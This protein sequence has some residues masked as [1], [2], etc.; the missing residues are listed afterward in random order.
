MIT[1]APKDEND[2]GLVFVRSKGSGRYIRWNQKKKL[3]EN[4][5]RAFMLRL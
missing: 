2:I 4:A 1:A 5:A 3:F